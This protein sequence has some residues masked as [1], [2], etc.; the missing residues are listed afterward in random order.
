M[1]TYPKKRIEIIIEAPLSRRMTEQLDRAGVS[2]YSVLPLTGGKGLLGSW[3][4]DGQISQASEMVAIIC[5]TDAELADEV[6][7]QVFSI[8]S[9]QMGI[10]SMSDVVVLRPDHF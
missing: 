1:K 9:R 6:L 7:A 3:S 5:I 8:V 10:V 4:A 2:G